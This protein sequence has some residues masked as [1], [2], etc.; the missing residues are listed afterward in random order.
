MFHISKFSK[1]RL[2]IVFLLNA[3]SVFAAIEKGGDSAVSQST[4]RRFLGSIVPKGGKLSEHVL[5]VLIDVNGEG[6]ER[7]RVSTVCARCS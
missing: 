2:S 1:S 4:A 3:L 5:S 7:H 6:G